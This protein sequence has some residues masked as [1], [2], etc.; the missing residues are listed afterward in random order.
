MNGLDAKIVVSKRYEQHYITKQA[1]NL[2]NIIT[3][4]V[5]WHD[6]YDIDLFFGTQKRLM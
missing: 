3:S 1:T 2:I 6:V 5:T 4:H